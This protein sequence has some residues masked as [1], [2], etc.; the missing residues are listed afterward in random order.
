[1]PTPCLVALH[2]PKTGHDCV[3][4]AVLNVPSCNAFFSYFFQFCSPWLLCQAVHTHVGMAVRKNKH[5]PSKRHLAVQ[6]VMQTRGVAKN[7]PKD[8][9]MVTTAA[10]IAA[11]IAGALRRT[12]GL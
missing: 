12:P 7:P 3:I 4:F 6:K 5:D 1:M 8:K 11:V 2:F 10:A 9:A